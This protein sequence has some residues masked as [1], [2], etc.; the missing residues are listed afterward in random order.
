MATTPMKRVQL[1]PALQPGAEQLVQAVSAVPGLP[2]WRGGLRARA[3]G[4]RRG[5]QLPPPARGRALQRLRP[6]VGA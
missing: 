6:S 1:P 4:L 2:V 3:Q 5:R